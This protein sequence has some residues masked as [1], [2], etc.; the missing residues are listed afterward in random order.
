M[1]LLDLVSLLRR[2][3]ADGDEI[4]LMGDFNKNVYLWRIAMLMAGDDLRLHEMCHRTT[5]MCLPPTHSRGWVLIN[6]VYG[7]ASLQCTAVALL[8][9]RAGFGNHWV[10]IVDIYSETILGGFFPR[11]IPIA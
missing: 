6:A 2:W 5:G 10:F 4:A 7:T 3:K 9:G 1:F 11:A 8:P